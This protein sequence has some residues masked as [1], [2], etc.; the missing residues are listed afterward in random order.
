[1]TPVPQDAEAE[2][3]SGLSLRE[4]EWWLP[5]VDQELLEVCPSCCRRRCR[6]DEPVCAPCGLR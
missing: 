1:M 3:R 2:R 4:M 5:D 6:P